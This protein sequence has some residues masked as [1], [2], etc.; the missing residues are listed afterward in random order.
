MELILIVLLAGGVY[1]AWFSVDAREQRRT[2]RLKRQVRAADRQVD[3]EYQRARRAMNDAA[4]QP[5][6]NLVEPDDV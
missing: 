2:D 1:V 3:A 5:W 4:E 6:R